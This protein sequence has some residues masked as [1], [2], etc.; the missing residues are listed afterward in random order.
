MNGISEWQLNCSCDQLLNDGLLR[1]FINSVMRD[2]PVVDFPVEIGAD[3][4]LDDVGD[5][6]FGRGPRGSLRRGG[7]GGI[8]RYFLFCHS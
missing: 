7:G 4:A 6:S 2:T 5:E 1:T 3:A 8:A